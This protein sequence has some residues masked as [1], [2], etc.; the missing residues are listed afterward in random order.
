MQVRTTKTGRGD[1][2]GIHTVLLGE[3][4]AHLRSKS[5]VDVNRFQV[6]SHTQREVLFFLGG[7]GGGEWWVGQELKARVCHEIF[8][9]KVMTSFLLKVYLT[10]NAVNVRARAYSTIRV[11]YNIIQYNTI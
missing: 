1:T 6:V 9:S 2:L 3:T 11:Q 7:E 10:S 8:G 5:R 4:E